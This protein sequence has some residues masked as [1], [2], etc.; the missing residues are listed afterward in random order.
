MY[1]NSGNG[2]ED[3][4]LPPKRKR[5][6]PELMS[7]LSA[8]RLLVH[9]KPFLLLIFGFISLGKYSVQHVGGCFRNFSKAD[10][11]WIGPYGHEDKT[12]N[13]F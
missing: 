10:D 6:V 3:V 12:T 13:L 1:C 11:E 5:F 9:V 7:A 2:G 4:P 8:R